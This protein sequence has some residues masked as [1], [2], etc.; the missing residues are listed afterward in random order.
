METLIRKGSNTKTK[1]NQNETDMLQVSLRSVTGATKLPL[2]DFILE[3]SDDLLLFVIL[4]T[5]DQILGA[6]WGKV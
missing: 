6:M 5:K 3:S 2:S 1:R 4:V